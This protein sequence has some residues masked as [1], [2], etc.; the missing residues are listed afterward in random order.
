MLAKAFWN[1][2]KLFISAPFLI[3]KLPTMAP[4]SLIPSIPRV[5]PC[6]NVIILNW[7][8]VEICASDTSAEKIL[9]NTQKSG[10]VT[11]APFAAQADRLAAR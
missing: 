4:L 3:K 1:I 9:K 6:G 11:M 8:F 5:V 7:Q 2:I 10:C